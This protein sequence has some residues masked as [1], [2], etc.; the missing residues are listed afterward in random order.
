M[1]KTEWLDEKYSVYSQL[2]LDISLNFLSIQFGGP[3][4]YNVGI[5]KT[6]KT[7]KMKQYKYKNIYLPD[8]GWK[9]KKTDLKWGRNWEKSNKC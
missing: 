7:T 9:S 1:P 8:H 5:H 4:V 2:L 6:N 3:Q